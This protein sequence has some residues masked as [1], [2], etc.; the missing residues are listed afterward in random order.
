MKSYY[1]NEFMYKSFEENKDKLKEEI[2]LSNPQLGKI[3]EGIAIRGQFNNDAFL[4]RDYR[5]ISKGAKKKHV[6]DLFERIQDII[7]DI[8][9][10]ALLG[11]CKIIHPLFEDF[12]MAKNYKINGKE[13]WKIYRYTGEELSSLEFDFITTYSEGCIGV[14]KEDK[15]GFI[16]REGNIVIPFEYEAKDFT[17]EPKYYAKYQ[18]HEGFTCVFNG[19]GFGFI[20]HYNIPLT[21]FVFEEYAEFKD[22]KAKVKIKINSNESVYELNK[23]GELKK[24]ST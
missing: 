12:V 8:N 19:E 17:Y 6:F 16:N 14:V 23:K 2:L 7:V 4:C 22:G 9:G 11:P 1:L 3:F 20:D 24:L 13:G 15:L 5:A 21:D 18:F 10:K